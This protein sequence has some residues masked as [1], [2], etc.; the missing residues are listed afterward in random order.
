MSRR[1]CTKKRAC[2]EFITPKHLIYI[3][4]CTREKSHIAT[5][6]HPTLPRAKTQ[7]IVQE[8]FLLS[9]FQQADGMFQNNLFKVARETASVMLATPNLSKA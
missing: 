3:R 5:R 6:P 7:T 1:L 2:H 9:L 8:Y 4:A